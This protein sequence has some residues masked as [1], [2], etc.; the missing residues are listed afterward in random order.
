MSAAPLAQLELFTL[1][2]PPKTGERGFPMCEVCGTAESIGPHRATRLDLCTRCWSRVLDPVGAA[3]WDRIEAE[4]RP[5]E[6]VRV[7]AGVL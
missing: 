4:A 2:P 6:T 3:S 5:V 1:A 7:L